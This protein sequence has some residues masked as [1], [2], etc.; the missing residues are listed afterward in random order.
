MVLDASGCQSGRKGMVVLFDSAL[1]EQ[2]NPEVLNIGNDDEWLYG[3]HHT[4]PCSSRR[5]VD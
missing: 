5:A 3:L 2:G 1:D 4:K